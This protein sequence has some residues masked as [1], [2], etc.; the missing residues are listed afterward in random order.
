MLILFN[1]KVMETKDKTR[2]AIEI[3]VI[4]DYDGYFRGW[5]VSLAAELETLNSNIKEIIVNSGPYRSYG[6]K[7]IVDDGVVWLDFYSAVRNGFGSIGCT[8]KELAKTLTN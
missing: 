2:K 8:T 3:T 7:Y 4:N 5:A 1:L 6:M